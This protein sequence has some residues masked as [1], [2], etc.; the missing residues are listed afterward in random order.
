MNYSSRNF[1]RKMVGKMETQFLYPNSGNVITIM[2]TVREG[3]T[4]YFLWKNA[5]QMLRAYG[6]MQ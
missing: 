5:V 4:I 2:T 1:R 6:M 3:S